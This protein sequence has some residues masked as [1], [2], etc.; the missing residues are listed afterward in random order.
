MKFL[1]SKYFARSIAFFFI[2]TPMILLQLHEDRA[3][4]DLAVS[5]RDAHQC[6]SIKR[7]YIKA[8]CF[9]KIANRKEGYCRLLSQQ[10]ISDCI[11][12]EATVLRVEA[13]NIPQRL[14]TL[15]I[16]LEM[17]FMGCLAI[18]MMG[19]TPPNLILK[20]ARRFHELSL[21]QSFVIIRLGLGLIS[22]IVFHLVWANIIS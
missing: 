12:K 4:M 22:M 19:L 20:Y 5:D 17:L 1:K 16:F 10:G 3:I 21:S 11:E 15:F 13:K 18:W 9:E 2:L 14:S 8:N 6:H 7:N